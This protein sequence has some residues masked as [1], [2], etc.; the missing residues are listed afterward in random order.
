MK[1]YS[2]PNFLFSLF[3][4]GIISINTSIAIDQKEDLN[5]IKSK[6]VEI[7]KQIR[8]LKIQH[9]K[10]KVKEITK[11]AD[12]D[13]VYTKSENVKLLEIKISTLKKDLHHLGK[14][15][16]H[17]RMPKNSRNSRRHAIKKNPYESYPELYDIS[18]VK[19]ANYAIG[20][21]S[22][23]KPFAIENYNQ[24]Q[25]IAHF[26]RSNFILSKNIDLSEK[27]WIPIPEF[28]GTFDGDNKEVT[29]LNW[30]DQRRAKE[31]FAFIMNL[32][33]GTIKNIKFNKVE[34]HGYRR[35]STIV[36][37]TIANSGALIENVHVS[38]NL[39]IA[40]AHLSGVVGAIRAGNEIKASSFTGSLKQTASGGPSDYGFVG[41][42]V[43]SCAGKCSSLAS[44]GS[45]HSIRGKVGG[46]VQQVYEQGVLFN[47]ES[48][49]NINP[50]Y[51]PSCS[52]GNRVG[53][54][55]AILA[56]EG[57]IENSH[58]TGTICAQH[59]V[60][61]LVAETWRIKSTAK[62]SN[63]SFKGKLKWNNFLGIGAIIGFSTRPII[64]ENIEWDPEHSGVENATG[65]R[66]RR[67]M[68]ANINKR[69]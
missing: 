62:I 60:G 1:R 14:I 30:K 28:F 54:L 11:A 6:A 10:L 34:V 20:D 18:K 12:S 66:N 42:V 52:K 43:R 57:S 9:T 19:K 64:L 24:L 39:S 23:S 13:K 27:Q 44:S 4:L 35:I 48:A 21:G 69:D 58:A 25:S 50:D 26:P 55:V 40:E 37:Q 36:D 32:D 63:S 7:K 47:S 61:G 49:M 8:D 59:Y 68:P 56:D 67:R 2:S 3:I 33:G 15:I 22:K 51:L 65:G 53:G 16:S 46:V 45:I 17:D 41:G 31:G 38:G 5:R 29:G